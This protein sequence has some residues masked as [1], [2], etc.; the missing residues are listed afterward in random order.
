MSSHVITLKSNIVT[1]YTIMWHLKMYLPKHA[2]SIF[3]LNLGSNI[4]IYNGIK[5]ILQHMIT[6]LIKRHE[7]V[8]NS[9]VSSNKMTLQSNIVTFDK[10]I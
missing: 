8:H 7:I 5:A 10:F 3:S 6:L 1:Y 4:L 2:T 9:A